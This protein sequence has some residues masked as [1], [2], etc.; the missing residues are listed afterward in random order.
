MGKRKHNGIQGQEQEYLGRISGNLPQAC[1]QTNEE[2][3]PDPLLVNM[4]IM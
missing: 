3:Y 2:I 1:N 4:R